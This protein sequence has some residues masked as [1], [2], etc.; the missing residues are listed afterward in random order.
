MPGVSKVE[1]LSRVRNALRDRGA[2]VDLP[3]DLEIGRVIRAQDNLVDVFLKRV[4]EAK[5][6]PYRAVNDGEVVTKVVQVME[7]LDARSALIPEDEFIARGAIIDALKSRNISLADPNDPDAAFN[8]DVGITGVTAA[9][10]ETASL[11][12]TSG[13]A[14][15]RL[16]SLAVP[17]HIAIVQTD[18]ILP[19]LIDWFADERAGTLP[20]EVLVSAP[21]KTADIELSL[22]MG[23]HGPKEEHVIVVG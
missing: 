22:V 9:V 15:R 19:D 20:C 10:A 2:P 3:T 6:H 12:L 7:R 1:F 23:V 8:V 16:A 17:N 11:V 4:E 14:Q 21:S 18:Q 5:M 13:G